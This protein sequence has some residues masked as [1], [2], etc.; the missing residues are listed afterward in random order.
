M[1]DKLCQQPRSPYMCVGGGGVRVP[2]PPL[3]SLLL[4]YQCYHSSL[5]FHFLPSLLSPPLRSRPH[6]AARGPGERLSS[7]QSLCKRFLV[8]FKL[9]IAHLV[10]GNGLEELFRICHYMIRHK[11]AINY[12]TDI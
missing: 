2:S 11:K 8:N 4:P 1:L 7:G 10:H 6:I 3:L 9:K 12:N 5:P